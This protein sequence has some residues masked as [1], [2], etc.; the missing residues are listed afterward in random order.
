MELKIEVY[1]LAKHP[2]SA[3]K[4]LLRNT[5]PFNDSVVFPFNDVLSSLKTIYSNK[6]ILV[7]FTII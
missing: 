2:A 7:N 5:I 6:H 4:E 3:R 1:E